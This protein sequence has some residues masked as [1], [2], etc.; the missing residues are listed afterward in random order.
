MAY[1]RTIQRSLVFSLALATP[2]LAPRSVYARPFFAN[3]SFQAGIR[4]QHASFPQG[5]TGFMTGGVAA[6]D[7]DS[8]GWTDLYFTRLGEGDMLYRNLGNG[9]FEN[10]TASAFGPAH[11]KGVRTNGVSFADIDNNGLQ[12]MFITAVDAT[13]YYL[14]INNGDGTFTEDALARGAALETPDTKH[15]MSVA[16]GDYDRDGYLDLFT[17]DWGSYQPDGQAH[18]RLLRN[19]GGAQAGHFEDVTL[20]AGVESYAG[21]P[22]F[23][24]SPRFTDLNHDGWPDLAIA[25]DFETSR[26]FWNNGDGTF[27]NGTAAANVGTD[28]NGMGSAVGDYN[29]DGQLDWFVTAIACAPTDPGCVGEWGNRLYT[30]IGG[31]AFFDT[32]DFAGVRNAGWGWASTWIDYDNDGRLDLMMTGSFDQLWENRG[33]GSFT[34]ARSETG[35]QYGFVGT[36]LAIFDYNNDGAMDMIVVENGGR[37]RLYRNVGG[38]DND[39]LRVRTIGVESNRDGIGARITVIPDLDLPWLFMVREIDGGSN[40]LSLNERAAHFGLGQDSGTIDKITIEWP[41]GIVQEFFD[42]SPNQWLHVVESATA[43]L[44]GDLDGNGRA[45]AFDVSAFELALAD[46]AAYQAQYPALPA[47]ILGDINSSGRFDAFDVARFERML[48]S[49]GT[50]AIVPQPATLATLLATGLL[51]ARRQ[52]RR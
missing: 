39:W 47:N 48:A 5:L 43:L 19:L 51:P 20:N 52:R 12:D 41:S 24:F 11:L 6:V 46:P 45:D 17:T 15:G 28:R 14:Y 49:S 2:V 44:L 40:Y 31:G 7:Y 21:D 22:V 34:N 27:S 29:N 38:D 18:A 23:G 42:V 35:L 25:A 30:N 26:L 9:T 3:L 36:G 13:R 10:V 16:F 1:R 50:S 4:H 33:D 32:T 8:D 37:P